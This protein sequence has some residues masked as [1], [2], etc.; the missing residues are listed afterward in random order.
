V[1][2]GLGKCSLRDD[3]EKTRKTLTA[4][5][6]CVNFIVC[7]EFK[8]ETRRSSMSKKAT[9]LQ[10]FICCIVK[11][12]IFLCI[13]VFACVFR[14]LARNWYN[15]TDNENGNDNKNQELLSTEFSF[16]KDFQH[17]MFPTFKTDFKRLDVARNLLLMPVLNFGFDT[18]AN[19][20][21]CPLPSFRLWILSRVGNW[22][23]DPS[24]GLKLREGL[25]FC[26]PE[27]KF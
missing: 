11:I 27:K 2:F 20:P 13:F 8:T 22:S 12:F 16:R 4:V 10:I 7:Q 21:C 23:V 26:W 3:L 24:V 25:R 9:P 5:T 1:D 14:W 17:K 6:N 19:S 18:W 15:G